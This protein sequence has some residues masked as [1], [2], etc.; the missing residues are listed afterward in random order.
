MRLVGLG[1]RLVGLGMRLVGLEMRLV[2]LE[3]RLVGLGMRLVGLGMRLCR[4]GNET[5]RSGNETIE[6]HTLHNLPHLNLM[7]SPVKFTLPTQIVI[8][9]T[10]CFAFYCWF[11]VTSNSATQVSQYD[12]IWALVWYTSDFLSLQ[13]RRT[14]KC[15]RRTSKC[16]WEVQ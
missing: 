14:S 9:E 1:M 8:R 12:N 2:G 10:K 4:S 13:L 5:S 6:G 7:Y 15:R 11:Q 16:R 3:M